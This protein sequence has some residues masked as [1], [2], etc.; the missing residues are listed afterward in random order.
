[1]TLLEMTRAFAG[2]A[3]DAESVEPYTIRAVRNGDRALFTRQKSQLQPASNPAARAAIHDLLASVVRE[4][5]GRAAR[6]KGPVEGKTEG[7]TGTSQNH[8][9]AW[10]IGFTNDIVVGVW[11]GNDDNRPTRG[12]TGG[13]LPARIWNEFVTQSATARAKAVRTQPRIAGLF[14]TAAPDAKPGPSGT[15]IRGVPVV[16]STG[17]LEIE[18]R[19]VRLFGVEG[20]RGRAVR[21]FKRY[22]G[23]REVA[24]EPAAGSSDYQCRVDDQD[25]SRVVLFNGGGRA[26]ANATPE[27]RALEQQARSTR[28]GIWSGRDDDED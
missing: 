4:G 22:L 8:K 7:R 11:V 28:V 26:T 20:T 10:F 14:A 18:G 27:L 12:V 6:V 9:D 2:I 19:V 5:T 1:V 24:G 16:Q 25:L 3:A 15:I 13:D 23:N 17:M 21:D